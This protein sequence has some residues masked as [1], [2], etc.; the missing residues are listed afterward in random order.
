MLF[1][2]QDIV[3]Q[4]TAAR[5][6][7]H[8][9]NRH[10]AQSED[11]ATELRQ[12]Y[13]QLSHYAQEVLFTAD[14]DGCFSYVAEGIQTLLG[15]E[16][17]ALVGRRIQDLVVLPEERELDSEIGKLI[18]R[19]K[20]WTARTFPTRSSA[21][22]TIPTLIVAMRLESQ[23]GGPTGIVGL[24]RDVSEYNEKEAELRRHADILNAVA[25]SA[26]RFLRS[27][28]WREQVPGFLEEIASS[29]RVCR[30]YLY[31][32]FRDVRN[33]L[34]SRLIAQWVRRNDPAQPELP[35]E[36][37]Y[38]EEIYAYLRRDLESNTE[39]IG[40]RA[41]TP[42]AVAR[43]LEERRIRAQY[44]LPV[45]IDDDWWGFLGF[46]EWYHE[47]TWSPAE[48]Q[49]FRTAVRILGAAIRQSETSRRLAQVE[50]LTR[51]QRDIAVTLSSVDNLDQALHSVANGIRGFELRTVAVRDAS[52]EGA[53]TVHTGW[54]SHVL[55][56]I[57]DLTASLLRS[58]EPDQ[59]RYYSLRDL[60]EHPEYRRF[61]EAPVRSLAILPVSKG[62]RAL[63]VIVLGSGDRDYIPPVLRETLEALAVETA[64]VLTRLEAEQSA[65]RNRERVH[66][67]NERYALATNAGRVG[68]WDYRRGVG[69]H[70]SALLETL[71]Q[72]G[73]RMDANPWA[74]LIQ[75][76]PAD[77]RGT[78]VQAVRD[79]VTGRTEEF[80]IEVPIQH[81]AGETLWFSFRAN[82]YR[83][84]AGRIERIIGTANDITSQKQLEERLR[85][86]REESESL[87]R[88]KSSFL[89]HMS[90]ELKTPLNG[91]IGY[92]QVLQRSI[93]ESAEQ[94]DAIDV[95]SRSAGHLLRLIDDVLDA[96]RLESGRLRL[97]ET[98]F[99]LPVFLQDLSEIVRIQAREKGLR[100]SLIK[101]T[102]LPVF[103]RGDEKRLRQ[104]LLNLLNNAVR[105]T[106]AG[107]V[108]LSAGWYEGN[109]RFS[110]KDTGVGIPEDVT[111]Q[112][113]QPFYQ[114]EGQ[115]APAEG[116]GLG[117]AITRQL[118]ELMGQEL[119]VESSVGVG[120][121]A[122]FL[123]PHSQ[124]E[125]MW[126]LATTEEYIAPLEDIESNDGMSTTDIE[127][128]VRLARIGD[129]GA[130][131][132][133]LER[134]AAGSRSV[135]PVVERALRYI[136]EFRI[137]EL[138]EL[139]LSLS[140]D[141]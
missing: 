136:R 22:R 25:D 116:S 24:L 120:T 12:G 117:L 59:Y 14:A 135:A 48:S 109:I 35:H 52:A 62:P 76:V 89:A 119:H 102:N 17:K 28:D 139:V 55:S 65:E 16:P 73:Q 85:R 87:S 58:V 32:N 88:A 39:V 107:S 44:V 90:H 121:E 69:F 5:N 3:Q 127:E 66:E 7:I 46:D 70:I 137:S 100:F 110:V 111:E 126:D 36:I 54:P 47:R 93:E 18:D 64:G 138:K 112:I 78:L 82:S 124:T 114:V 68:V 103:V 95:I 57:Q 74:V 6:E 140:R 98:E 42:D 61:L 94:R 29:A 101:E 51:V 123:F 113:F 130:M 72:S 97:K 141:S 10:L 34:R 43:H 60:A 49:A 41:E 50:Y 8:R 104:V 23:G 118:L 99:N 122:W 37:T 132:R 56:D 53:N 108:S 67:A 134:I 125:D 77:H 79:I 128:L 115:N 92:A 33:Q 31:E 81:A 86:A 13:R 71:I 27:A 75:S 133:V 40:V 30:A 19:E 83:D 91:I 129:I 96:S 11:R 4:L 21:G 80:E 63:G 26:R 131:E 38:R 15:Y 2:S 1:R 105:F 84:G 9:L 45:F 20:E 106:H